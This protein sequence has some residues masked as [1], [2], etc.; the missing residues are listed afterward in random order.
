MRADNG[1][2]VND[3]ITGVDGA[4]AVFIAPNP[5]GGHSE[6]RIVRFDALN[7]LAHD[8]RINRQ[9]T[10]G[11]NFARRDSSDRAIKSHIRA[12]QFAGCPLRERTEL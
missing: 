5:D 1:R 4:F 6:S 12:A 11:V 3:R 9:I 7:F 10:I 2:R 8:A